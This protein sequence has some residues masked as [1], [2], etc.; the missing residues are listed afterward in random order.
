MASLTIDDF[1]FYIKPLNSSKVYAQV[2]I[3]I[4]DTIEIKGFTISSSTEMHARFQEYIWIQ[5]PRIRMG[6]PKWIKIVFI[7]DKLLWEEIESKIYDLYSTLPK[8][9]P[10][11]ETIEE[12]VKVEDIPF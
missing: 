4:C 10:V 12:E 7:D 1:D 5:P 11:K 3:K 2:S 9:I 8:K 6:G